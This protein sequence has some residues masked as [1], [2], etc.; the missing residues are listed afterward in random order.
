MHEV[1]KADPAARR[2][3][4]LTV[5][6][7]VFVGA[8]LIVGFEWYGNSLRDWVGSQPSELPPRLRLLL[9]LIAILVSVPLVAFGVHLRSLGAKVL[10]AQQWPPPGHRVLRDTPVVGGRAA[11]V[12]GR[13]FKLMA[14]GLGVAS[15]L[16][17]L[18]LW[19]LAQ[20]LSEGA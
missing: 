13:A 4:V 7:G 20:L 1:R 16:L 19:R 11:M 17:W 18:L 8:L 5:V 6:L 3:V 2:Q 9:L 14:L 10:R 12:R 15:A